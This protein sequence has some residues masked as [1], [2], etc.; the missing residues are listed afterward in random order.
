M[1]KMEAFSTIQNNLSEVKKLMVC[2]SCIHTSTFNIQQLFR[3]GTSP[4]LVEV[5]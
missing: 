3:D 4:G 2:H 1:F 5:H